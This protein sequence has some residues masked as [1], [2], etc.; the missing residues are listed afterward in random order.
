[1]H[2]WLSA[3]NTVCVSAL[4]CK[5]TTF[6]PIVCRAARIRYV[7]TVHLAKNYYYNSKDIEFSYGI[8]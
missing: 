2:V 3:S 7:N 1:M 8:I 4:P 5:I 6:R